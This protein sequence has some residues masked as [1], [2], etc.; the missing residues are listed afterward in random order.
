MKKLIL[1]FVALGI[2]LISKAQEAAPAKSFMDDPINDP[3]LPVYLLGAFVLLVIVLVMVVAIYLMRILNMLTEQA[4][5]QNAE[6]AGKAYVPP[7]TWWAGVWSRLNALVPVEQEKNIEMDH[8]YDGIR[9]LDN[10]LPPWWKWLFYGTI[11]WSVIYLI[12]FHLSGTLPLSQQEYENEMAKASEE[13]RKY[14]ASQPQ[15]TIDVSTLKFAADPAIIEKGRSVFMD[16]N[17]GS[18]HRNDGGGNTIGPNLTDAYWLHGGDVKSIYSTVRDG[19]VEKGMPSW[20]RS[21]SPTDVRDVTFFIMSLQGS[22]PEN[23]KPAQGELFKEVVEN[24]DTT[25]VQAAL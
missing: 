10:H 21:L 1:S 6:Q 22:D 8:D 23:A 18:C 15:A 2:V 7:I 14:R 20:G 19:V 9:E 4:A 25:K 13:M 11:G 3:M 17:C 16:N 12:V 5:R 24:S